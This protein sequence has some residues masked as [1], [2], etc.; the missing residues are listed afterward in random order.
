MTGATSLRVLAAPD[1]FRGTASASEIAA[2]IDAAADAAR[3]TCDMAPMADGGE[4]TLD[5][6]EG[7][8]RRS[9]VTGPTGATVFASWRLDSKRA[10]VEMAQASGLALAGGADR[11]DPIGATSAGTGELI[12]EAVSC[13]ARRV[14]VAAGGSATTDGGSGALRALPPQEAMRGVKMIVA[15]DVRTRFVDA[16]AVFG[17]Q[18]GA[19]RAQ[20]ELLRLRLARLA[21]E[22]LDVYGIDVTELDGSGAAGGLAGGLAA[23]GAKL[24]NGFEIVAEEIGLSR[25]VRAADLVITGEGRLDA[26]SFEGKVVGSVARLAHRS[27]VPTWAVVGAAE[28]SLPSVPGLEVIDLTQ[29]FGASRAAADPVDCVRE[30]VLEKLEALRSSPGRPQPGPTL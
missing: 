30:A 9:K 18:K 13:G 28:P 8:N 16:A 1:K 2:A 14:T 23:R 3:M 5:A 12:A 10:V 29:R 15:C 19:S 27:G 25:R 22:Y 17:P 26:T 7:G 4:G 20:V 11:N 6:L 21:R 24:A